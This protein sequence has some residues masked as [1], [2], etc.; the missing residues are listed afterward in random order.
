MNIT[1]ED[2]DRVKELLLISKKNDIFNMTTREFN[3]F[4]NKILDILHEEL[5][6]RE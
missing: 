4:E 2:I 6:I 1:I 5:D 3:E